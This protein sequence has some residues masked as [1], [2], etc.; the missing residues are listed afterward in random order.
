MLLGGCTSTPTDPLR[1]RVTGRRELQMSH[2]SR[3]GS[4]TYWMMTDGC[5]DGS[6]AGRK[7][8]S[9]R[10]TQLLG[11]WGGNIRMVLLEK[12]K[13]KGRVVLLATHQ[14]IFK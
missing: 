11:S 5:R 9:V 12:A 2:L 7:K 8:S 3:G 6:V 1:H 4:L 13:S 14:M 10:K